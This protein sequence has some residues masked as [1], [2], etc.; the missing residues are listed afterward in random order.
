MSSSF[1]ASLSS[2]LLNSLDVKYE[3]FNSASDSRVKGA[4]A[5]TSRHHDDDSWFRFRLS[6]SAFFVWLK[7]TQLH[8]LFT[9]G[10][11]IFQLVVYWN[12]KTLPSEISKVGSI[13]IGWSAVSFISYIKGTSSLTMWCIMFERRIEFSWQSIVSGRPRLFILQQSWF[14]TAFL[15]ITYVFGEISL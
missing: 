11:C 6:I 13:D 5:P 9:I 15:L 8:F 4:V 2:P 1:P 7:L 14:P 3:T 10:V 12:A